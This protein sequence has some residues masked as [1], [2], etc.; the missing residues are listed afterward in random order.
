VGHVDESIL[1]LVTMVGLITIGLSTYLILYSKPLYE[2][3]APLQTVFERRQL[4]PGEHHHEVHE[5]DID[6]IVFGGGR[7]GTLITH[8][9]KAKGLRVTVIDIDPDT[10]ELCRKQGIDVIFGDA[11]DPEFLLSIPLGQARWVVSTVRGLDIHLALAHGLRAAGY[12]GEIVFTAHD[13]IEA[14]RLQEADVG[15]VIAPFAVAAQ[16]VVDTLIAS[17]I[18]ARPADED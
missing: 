16:R 4:H 8:G 17:G 2:K 3:L 14:A 15:L 5:G 6:V 18:T 1:G 7:H 9:L 12:T 10:I 13:Q 11:E